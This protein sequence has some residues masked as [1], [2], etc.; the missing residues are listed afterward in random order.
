MLCEQLAAPQTRQNIFYIMLLSYICYYYC[1]K[2]KFAIHH[3]AVI[4]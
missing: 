3:A 2:S 1:L 4:T